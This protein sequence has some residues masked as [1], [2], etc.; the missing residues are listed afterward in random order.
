MA[1]PPRRG[2]GTSERAPRNAPV[3]VRAPLR[4]TTSRIVP[5][6]GW[7]ASRMPT[8]HDDSRGVAANPGTARRK[9]REKVRD[10]P[11]CPT[12]AIDAPPAARR[13]APGRLRL[14]ASPG[15]R[16]PPLGQAGV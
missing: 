2:A 9:E 11:T 7:V 14:R 1:M 8:F 4:I 6:G 5:P 13:R 15:E 10:S 16:P 3:G 12:I